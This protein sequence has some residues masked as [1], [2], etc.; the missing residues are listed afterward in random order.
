MDP[1][2]EAGGGSITSV[3]FGKGVGFAA[4]CAHVR[5]WW[6]TG[7]DVDTGTDAEA[8]ADVDTGTDADAGVDVDTGTDADAGLDVDAGTDADAGLD[9]DAGTDAD[10][11]LADGV[12]PRLLAG[13]KFIFV[14]KM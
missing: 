4:T 2:A 3:Y 10:A 1:V 7:A 13:K 9:V 6:D 11:G 5:N 12:A 8:G 14:N